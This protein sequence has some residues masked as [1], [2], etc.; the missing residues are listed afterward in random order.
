[1]GEAPASGLTYL[2]M[3]LIA[4]PNLGDLLEEY[5]RLG[6]AEAARLL[7]P[8]ARALDYSHRQGVVHRDVKPS[9]ILLRRRPSLGLAVSSTTVLRE[10]V[11]PLLSD[12]G[13]ARALDAPDLTSAGRT[14]GT[15]TYMSPEQSADSHELDGRSDLYSLGAVF[16]RCVVGRPPFGGTTTQIL[17]A[18][19]YEPL[20][21]PQELLATLPPLAVEILQNTLAK[22]P[23]ERYPR[24]DLLATAFER[25]GGGAGR[26]VGVA[27]DAGDVT[28][29]LPA[30]AAVRQTP[31]R[32]EVLVPGVVPGGGPGT[33][34]EPPQGRQTATS[35]QSRS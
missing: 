14:I 34:T 19:V 12:F 4:G 17:H 29:T 22:N 1:M 5:G 23:D 21:V 32:M 33:A 27:D 35:L 13:I 16:F 30:L 20:V 24:G 6:S 18:H 7:A 15:P 11:L 10:P 26:P 31:Q 28:A 25:L 2:V 8:I 9:N 3:E